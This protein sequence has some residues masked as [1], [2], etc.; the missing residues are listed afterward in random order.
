MYKKLIHAIALVLLLA[1]GTGAQTQVFIDDF[2]T[3][4]IYYDP[5]TNTHDVTGTIWDDFIGWYTGE[6]VDDLS[7]SHDRPG[8]LYIGSTNAVWAEPWNP[9]G[10][11]LFKVVKG[12]FVATVRVTDYAGTLNAQVFSNDGGLM[13]R[14][15]KSP[16]DAGPGEDWVTIDYFP[17]WTGNMLWEARDDVRNEA[18]SCSYPGNVTNRYDLVRPYLRLERTGN[19]FR[20]STSRDG[21]E[22]IE[23]VCSPKTRNDFA[24]LP[25]QVGI[26]QCNYT[27]NN[28]GVYSYVAFDDFRLEIIIHLK[29][30][31]PVPANGANV[32]PTVLKWLPGDYAVKHDVYFGTSLTDVNNATTS[33]LGI[34]KI[35]QDPNSY[36]VTNLTPGVTY[37]WRIDEVNDAHPDKV[38]KGDVWRFTPVPLKA[39]N[40]KPS[41][42]T[43]CV[44]TNVVLSWSPGIKASTHLVFFGTSQTAVNNATSTSP[45]YKGNPPDPNYTFT[46]KLAYDTVYYWRINERNTDL[47]VT[48]G[49]V[50]SFRTVPAVP[51]KDPN[52]VGWWP[53]DGAT[54]GNIVLDSSGHDH[55]GK[56]VNG[57]QWISGVDRGALSFD[58]RDDYVELPLTLGQALSSLT[59]ST[60]AIWVDS[61]PGGPW[62]RIFDFGKDRTVYM[63]LTPRWWFMDETYFHITTSGFDGE[64]R[65]W[66]V[67][68]DLP[69]GW[70]HL[71]VTIDAKAGTIILYY[72]G[73]ELARATGAILTPKDLGVTTNNWLG[74]SHDDVNDSYYLGS[75][76]D[77]RIYNY[78]MTEAQIGK[79]VRGLELAWNPKPS[80]GSS[81]DVE[82][83]VPLSWS[84][85]DN[86]AK[87]DVYFGT[88]VNS[89]RDANT[90]DTTGIY[91][92]R[93]DPNT[94]TPPETLKFG[95][96][97]YWRIEE[98]NTDTTIS[99]GRV[100]SFTTADYLVVDDFEAY[101]N[102][103][104]NRV[105]Q[106][107]L[108]GI[109]YSA[110]Q[111]FP[112][113]YGGN[114]TGASVGHDIWTAGTPYTT[115]MET[116][117]IHGGGQSMPMYYDNTKSP[118]YSETTRVFA[119]PQDW[120]R[121]DVKSLTLWFRG[122]PANYIEPLYVVVEDSVSKTVNHQDPNAVL[123]FTW[124]EWSIPLKVFS[125][126][127]VNLKSIKKIT[128]RVGNKTSSVAS[129]KGLVYFDDI[130]LYPS[131]C[132]PSL[133][134]QAADFNGDCIINYSDIDILAGQWL[135]SG[136]LVTPVAPGN[137][138][139]VGYWKFDEGSGAVAAD[140]S[141]K[142]NNG[143]LLGEP[144]WVA[145][146]HGSALRFG[147]VDE[148]V[149]LPIGS[150]ISTLTNSTF[151]IWANFPST[152]NTGGTWQRIFDIG[153]GVDV[154][155]FLTPRMGTAGQMRFAITTSAGTGEIQV[156]SPNTLPGGW[157]HVAVTID[158]IAK[159]ITLY[160]DGTAVAR[161]TQATLNPSNLG[162]TTNNWLGKSQFAADAYYA[163]LLD[164]FQIYNRAL[165]RAEVAWLAGKTVPFSEPYDLNV[166]GAVSFKDFAKLAQ[167]W[168]EEKLWPF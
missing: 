23:M 117:I 4:H 100:W 91:R 26:R 161:N 120:T 74:R 166:D 106:T 132:A 32:T 129:G 121:K 163:G 164:D 99:K 38:W 110:D 44:P 98:Y 89:V 5:N 33:T 15:F 16:D 136:L 60:L 157:H 155:M 40:P 126:A 36:P 127:G 7:A 116:T 76:A 160:L 96:T 22:W 67:G 109:G 8:Q 68:F 54:C 102:L 6:T 104:P 46:T 80:D 28:A 13:A 62:Q 57:P 84:P 70:H 95:Q 9:L 147:G 167:G 124:Q 52:L 66:S 12:D 128:L 86:A 63:C 90:S 122:D 69:S 94:Y 115:I 35:R 17:V 20:F 51:I 39:W 11:F 48:K 146:Y 1:A 83:A 43:N 97:Y 131:R 123:S 107:W 142:G 53:L 154:Y 139:L 37:Y 92:P 118:Y 65:V 19:T 130:R 151:A 145:G 58:G 73:S 113:A 112:V 149:E 108:D 111:Y 158:A 29:A 148:Y 143:N 78:A 45:E 81:T 82:R 87:H 168:L 75:M 77:F 30:R 3:P 50:W 72:D 125:D 79:L 159:T 25:L 31:N 114:S 101:N 34:Y 137:A 153:T 162:V 61:Q 105:F 10:P 55:H 152:P 47:S 134:Q 156:T 49:D 24:G 2:N 88:D 42:G 144:Q 14:A 21:V 138:N 140:S 18:W 27:W 85:G 59:S 165:S 141:G 133:L 93:Q 41:D 135:N 64:V 119:T 71:A 150:L 56:L 103:S